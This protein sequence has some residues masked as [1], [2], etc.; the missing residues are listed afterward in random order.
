MPP[1]GGVR[2]YPGTKRRVGGCL[3]TICSALTWSK[4]GRR[5]WGGMGPGYALTLTC[6]FEV[7]AQKTISVKPWVGNMRKQMPPMTRPSLIKARVLCFLR[8]EGTDCSPYLSPKCCPGSHSPGS[9]SCTQGWE[10][11]SKSSH[12]LE[13]EAWGGVGRSRRV[14]G[15]VALG[16]GLSWG[17]TGQRRGGRC[18]PWACVATGGR[19]HSAALQARATPAGWP[20]ASVSCR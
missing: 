10:L 13:E 7:T 14:P 16:L 1:C 20:W 15:C 4:C 5:W 12:R 17:R 2:N 3:I 19:R 8:G 18:T 11:R 6:S 9:L